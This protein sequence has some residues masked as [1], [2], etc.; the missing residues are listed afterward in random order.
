VPSRVDAWPV[1]RPCRAASTELPSPPSSAPRCRACRPCDGVPGGQPL[2]ERE[3]RAL[4]GVALSHSSEM[5]R[6][7]AHPHQPVGR[8]W[9]RRSA[10]SSPTG[11]ESY[12]QRPPSRPSVAVAGYQP[13]V[14]GDRVPPDPVVATPVGP[15][16]QRSGEQAGGPREALVP[17]DG[18]KPALPEAGVASDRA[19]AQP[20]GPARDRGLESGAGR[21]R[22]TASPTRSQRIELGTRQETPS[23]TCAT[24]SRVLRGPAEPSPLQ[25]PS[26]NSSTRHGERLRTPF[27]R[28]RT[29]VRSH[30][31]PP[32]RPLSAP[33]S[34]R[35]EDPR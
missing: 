19:P 3:P 23:Q 35:R 24:S 28:R 26:A 7:T 6:A 1:R 32:H 8:S 13:D 25:A 20:H 16:A 17:S 12:W 4:R 21:G 30:P 31:C 15:D 22:Q 34:I 2:P 9:P 10:S 29:P 33:T 14:G 11:G 18:P 5:L 27:L